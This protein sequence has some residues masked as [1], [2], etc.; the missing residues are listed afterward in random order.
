VDDVDIAGHIKV[1]QGG[2]S[3]QFPP[4]VKVVLVGRIGKGSLRIQES[5]T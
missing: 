3:S 1:R 4:Y 5:L 2:K